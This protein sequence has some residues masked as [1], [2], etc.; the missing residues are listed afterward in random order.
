ML[1]PTPAPLWL[2]VH[3]PQLALEAAW[4]LR[5]RAALP[6]TLAVH[7]RQR[8]VQVS[9]GARHAGVRPGM[10]LAAAQALLPTLLLAPRQLDLE[11]AHTQALA[12][13]LQAVSSQVAVLAP[14]RVVAEVGASVRLFGGIRAVWRHSQNA[15]AG[16]ALTRRSALAPSATG[17]S[18]LAQARRP[19]RRRVVQ[20]ASLRHAL[21]ALPWRGLPQAQPHTEWLGTLG[22]RT[23]GDL[24]ALPRPELQRRTDG[25]LLTALDQAYGLQAPAVAWWQPPARFVQRFELAW[26][27]QHAHDVLTAAGL[28]LQQLAAWLRARHEVLDHFLLVLHHDARHDTAQPTEIVVRVSRAGAHPD[29]WQ[30]VL[31]EQ[32]R[33][34]T[35]VAPVH[36]LELRAGPAQAQG[37][38]SHTLF[39]SAT[40]ASAGQELLDLLVARLGPAAIRQPAPQPDYRPECANHWTPVSDP[41]A[42]LADAPQPPAATATWALSWPRPAWLLAQP[43]P[44]ALVAGQPAYAGVP[45]RLHQGPERLETGWW[46]GGLH[47]RDYFI[48]ADVQGRCCWIYRTRDGTTPHWWLHGWFG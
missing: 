44:L 23:L 13:C 8:I 38:Q 48:A 21:N 40:P 29:P 16:L 31:A 15:L 14:H 25:S 37:T 46:E 34:A 19:W 18:L 36:A 32:L 1:A 22:C 3:L 43:E 4:P 6:D 45:L 35:W 30:R 5:T 17:A 12:L 47:A 9:A 28:V 10:R 27:V 41:A 24:Q 7:Q 2:A 33:H 39:P 26:P 20:P 42:S 11:H